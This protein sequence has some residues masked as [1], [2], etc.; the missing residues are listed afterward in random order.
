M[1]LSEYFNYDTNY[2]YLFDNDEVSMY[3]SRGFSN[4]YHM[5]LAVNIDR[6]N[7]LH[8][9]PEVNQKYRA[10][11]SFV[12]TLY[13]SPLDDLL[14]CADD[15]AKGF[16]EGLFQ[17][18]FR[19]YGS[20]F[21]EK[22]IPDS[23]IDSLNSTY[24]K[25]GTNG[26]K[27]N[28]L[29]LAYAI[30]AQITHVERTILLESLAENHDLHFYSKENNNLDS[31]VKQ[32]G[33]VKYLDE[34]NAVFRNSTLNLCPTLKSITSGIPLR[35]LDILANRAV[36]F[37]NFQPELADYFNDGEDVIMYESI[38]D[39]LE[40][41]DFYLSNINLLETIASSGYEKVCKFF[42]YEDKIKEM[43]HLL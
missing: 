23:L 27:L 35:A 11:I 20:N 14:Y 22:A 25:Y 10:D 13:N 28:K 3:K 41:A 4:V 38:E 15:Y 43:L 39:A 16:V 6:I 26:L 30:N 5:P 33:P 2:I 21:V 17:T 18:Q 31:N 1:R 24:E 29:G 19:V 12:G 40:K 37:S 34:M 42:S 36:L 32:H 9:S 8:F 7:N